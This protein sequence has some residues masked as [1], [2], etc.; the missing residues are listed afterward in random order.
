MKTHAKERN[1]NFVASRGLANPNMFIGNSIIAY[2][3][4]P[5]DTAYDNPNEENGVYTKYL[6]MA[7][8]EG[9][10]PIE[11]VFKKVARLVKSETG[12]K[13]QPWVHSNSDRDVFLK[14]DTETSSAEITPTETTP[15]EPNSHEPQQS[16]IPERQ[17][18][19]IPEL[20]FWSSDEVAKPKNNNF[21]LSLIA[22]F[23]FA[24]VGFLAFDKYEEYRIAE[25]KRIAEMQQRTVIAISKWSDEFNLGLPKTWEELQKVEGIVTNMTKEEALSW[26]EE[27]KGK[28]LD[29]Y[30]FAD[31]KNRKI[32]YLPKELGNLTNLQ[33]L[34][35]SRNELKELP[36]SIGNLTN[37]Q[38]LSLGSNHF[39]ETEKSKIRR[40][41]P[42]TEIEF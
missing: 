14:G 3:T 42:N 28:N 7:I 24:I 4:A 32:T 18:S 37:L 17:Q 29:F 10:I 31:T 27:N 2:S 34:D 20:V 41:L 33:K 16:S 5:N 21:L 38:T 40:L 15:T 13:Q 9:G 19:S 6:K 11:S 1:L 30:Y 25:E 39:S 26:Q 35:L 12:N 36:S 22:F 23:L 8:L